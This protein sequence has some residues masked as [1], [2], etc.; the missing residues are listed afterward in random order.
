MSFFNFEDEPLT[1]AQLKEIDDYLMKKLGKDDMPEPMTDERLKDIKLMF[2]SFPDF[3]R[4]P[5]GKICDEM[6]VELERLREE[7]KKFRLLA[8]QREVGLVA[9]SDE[10]EALRV[11]CDRLDEVIR[12]AQIDD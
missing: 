4:P 12:K 3:L 6:V 1:P 5:V 2:A 7:V 8:A 10:C 9:R 11:E